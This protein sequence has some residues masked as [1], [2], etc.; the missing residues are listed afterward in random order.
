MSIS[1]ESDPRFPAGGHAILSVSSQSDGRLEIYGPGREKWLSAAGWQ[2]QRESI[3]PLQHEANPGGETRIFLP[4][5]I[6][7]HVR[8]FEMLE[9]TI[10]G[11]SGR[12][13]W[14][15]DVGVAEGSESGSKG[16]VLPRQPRRPVFVDS[17][18]SAEVS[19]GQAEGDAPTEGVIPVTADE[20]ASPADK[21]P[22]TE[23]VEPESAPTDEPS[24][25]EVDSDNQGKSRKNRLLLFALLGVAVLALAALAGWYLLRDRGGG[26]IEA[27]C[28]AE[29]LTGQTDLAFERRFEQL[30]R[31]GSRATDD[32]MLSILEEGASTGHGY[33][34]FEFGRIYDPDV[35]T[36]GPLQLTPSRSVAVRYYAR[37]SEAGVP[38]AGDALRSACA[39]L[40]RSDAIS[41]S[42]Y[43]AHCN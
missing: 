40:D 25:A 31:C 9:I 19:S 7:N 43:D 11:V 20:S 14:P 27:E 37:A 38:E 16:E 42:V 8:G 39:R 35:T 5:E 21:S 22:D 41:A 32:S 12:V 3:G 1:L 29:V 13:S 4:P 28:S 6:C 30:K 24:Q 26:S 2:T 23:V 18:D 33:S 10:G 34:L 36:D 15:Q 17:L